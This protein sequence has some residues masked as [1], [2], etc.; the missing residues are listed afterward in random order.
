MKQTIYFN[1]KLK[2]GMFLLL[3]MACVAIG[4]FMILGGEKILI[5]WLCIGFF[6]LGT[7]ICLWAIFD[8]RPR[9]I[10]DEDGVIDRYLGVGK[11]FWKDIK[12]LSVRTAYK[13][14]FVCL[15]MDEDPNQRYL[16]NLS[17]TK[18][19]LVT[20][21]VALGWPPMV[22]NLSGVKGSTE[23]IFQAIVQQIEKV[24]KGNYV[25]K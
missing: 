15:A 2:Y 23:K 21:S 4:A 10:L 14:D 17:S 12:G 22:L 20:T 24:D 16:S 5:G 3:S 8:S 9:L 19:K 13:N 7:L 1:S 18:R 11:I 6:F 25:D